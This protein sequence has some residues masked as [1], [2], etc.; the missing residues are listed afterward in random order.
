MD[1]FVAQIAV[2]SLIGTFGTLVDLTSL[3]SKGYGWLTVL[4]FFMVLF[5]WFIY[6]VYGPHI[7]GKT[8]TLSPFLHGLPE[9]IDSIG[10]D[11]EEVKRGLKEAK[12]EREEIRVQQKN[13]MQVQ[14]AQA[15]ANDQMDENA[16]DQ[17]LRQ[18]GVNV[19]DFLLS[20]EEQSGLN[21][22]TRFN[23]RKGDS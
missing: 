6:Q 9:R 15:R 16:V 3:W 18:N 22:D 11:V 12:E 7:L 13:Q 21:E 14:R 17:Y 20:D 8:T 1:I 23:F 4:L 19:N 5:S 2:G 10:E